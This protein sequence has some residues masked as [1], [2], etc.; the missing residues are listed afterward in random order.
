[1]PQHFALLQQLCIVV[2]H[3][4]LSAFTRPS[5]LKHA[6]PKVSRNRRLVI[7]ENVLAMVSPIHHVIN[8]SRI[9]DA[10]LACQVQSV[11][12]ALYLP[13]LGMV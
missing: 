10:S 3:C 7:P 1:M 6:S 2:Y 5:V 8:R 9:L 11:C 12:Y 4:I 13:I